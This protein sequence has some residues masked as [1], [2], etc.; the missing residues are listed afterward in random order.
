MHV[1]NLCL[2]IFQPFFHRQDNHTSIYRDYVQVHASEM[3]FTFNFSDWGVWTQL[4]QLLAVP[5]SKPQHNK[6][7]WQKQCQKTGC[8]PGVSSVMTWLA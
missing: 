3:R 8:H 5:L 2:G 1:L 7:S 6:Q 4:L